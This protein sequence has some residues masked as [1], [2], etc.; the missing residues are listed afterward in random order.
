[1]VVPRAVLEAAQFES[2]VAVL[3]VPVNWISVLGNLCWAS[4]VL[5]E[6]SEFSCLRRGYA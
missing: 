1:M 6:L 4:V 3:F 5:E 2:L